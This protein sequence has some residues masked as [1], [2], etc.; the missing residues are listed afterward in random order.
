[1]AIPT[2]ASLDRMAAATKLVEKRLRLDLRGKKNPPLIA[3]G[4]GG[5]QI[6]V[7][8]TGSSQDGTNKRWSYDFIEVEQVAAG[9]GNWSDK[10]GGI[11]GTMRNLLEDQNAASG[12]F[13]NG[14]DS[15][16]LTG[17]FDVQPIPTGTRV[18]IVKQVVISGVTQYWCSVANGIDGGCG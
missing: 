6:V 15:A 17:S 3:R 14:V 16:N 4:G 8:I 13:G 10:S 9:Y 7:R 5:T 2:K 18:A 12:I 1:M 11:T